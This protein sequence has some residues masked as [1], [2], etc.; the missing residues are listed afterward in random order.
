MSFA[1]FAASV[2]CDA[3]PPE[4]LS[5]ALQALWHDHHGDWAQA[6][7]LA[8]EDRSEDGALVHAYL[9]REEG[10][11]ANAGYWYERAGRS[12]PV[13]EVTLAAEWEQIAREL[14]G[15]PAKA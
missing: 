12:R 11:R 9:H 4:G 8:Q 5:A 6:H 15:E 10:D 1:E 3:A 7:A 14:L 13:D 2:A